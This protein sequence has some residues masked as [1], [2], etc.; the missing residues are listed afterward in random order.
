ME[1]GA[2]I[3]NALE[4]K[5]NDPLKRPNLAEGAFFWLNLSSGGVAGNNEDITVVGPA[6]PSQL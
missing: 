2:K 1:R 4:Q 6:A 5:F 3:E